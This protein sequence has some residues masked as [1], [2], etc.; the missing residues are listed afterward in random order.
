MA[1]YAVEESKSVTDNQG[2]DIP[3]LFPEELVEKNDWARP[4][5]S[6]H[7]LETKC[8]WDLKR[9]CIRPPKGKRWNE[10]KSFIPRKGVPISHLSWILSWQYRPLQF[11]LVEGSHMNG[12]N[13]SGSDSTCWQDLSA[14]PSRWRHNFERSGVYQDDV[15]TFKIRGVGTIR[16]HGMDMS[17]MLAM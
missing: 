13:F 8:K 10:N 6:I 14:V 16:F 11:R 12:F 1:R 7:T 3:D 9:L 5:S 4:P 17:L 15:P 2:S